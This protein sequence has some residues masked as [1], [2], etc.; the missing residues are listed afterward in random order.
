MSTEARQPYDIPFGLQGP[1]SPARARD[2]VRALVDRELSRPP[3][4]SRLNDLLL[5]VSELVTNAV[6]H[7][8]G[9]ASCGVRLDSDARVIV[10]EVADYST[11]HPATSQA[12]D[13]TPGGFGWPIITRL[14]TD[15]TVTPR[16][17]G[18]TISVSFQL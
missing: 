13:F 5:V 12:G 15:V 10:L 9:V 7:G 16:S 3:E 4:A 2:H 11:V 6:R 8:G 14:S 18:K 1:V 17:G